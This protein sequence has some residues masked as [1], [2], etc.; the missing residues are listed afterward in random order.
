[1]S[2]ELTVDGFGWIKN[3]ILWNSLSEI[4]MTIVMMDIIEAYIELGI[5]HK[6]LPFL[7]EI[8]KG[9]KRKNWFVI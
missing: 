3:T 2:Q 1:M 5:L 4:I 7:L 9:N 6:E 8:I